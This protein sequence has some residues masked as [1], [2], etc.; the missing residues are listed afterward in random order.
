MPGAPAVFARG[1]RRWQFDDTHIGLGRY[2]AYVQRI[3][4]LEPAMHALSDAEL[5]SATPQLKARLAA[6]EPLDG[7]LP[8][9][10]AVVREASVRVLGM[11][12]YDVQLV[13]GMLSIK[14]C[15]LN[16]TGRYCLSGA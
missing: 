6:G 11:R 16:M 9:A 12:H 14:L 2:M 7:L 15:R 5:Q 4:A 1:A 13:R 8:E 10:F 3:N